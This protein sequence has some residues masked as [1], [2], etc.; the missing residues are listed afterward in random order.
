M[1]S[2]GPDSAEILRRLKRRPK[3]V[4]ELD[5]ALEAVRDDLDRRPES[6]RAAIERKRGIQDAEDMRR[7]IAAT[8]HLSDAEFSRSLP[9]NNP[10]TE[11]MGFRRKWAMK[12]RWNSEPARRRR[13]TAHEVLAE[14]SLAAGKPLA[15]VKLRLRLNSI[16][17]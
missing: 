15:S 17:G 11:G 14:R 7:F 1:P 9:E 16:L 4:V 3:R 5:D 13:R 2:Y 10:L 12:I 6:V 8:A